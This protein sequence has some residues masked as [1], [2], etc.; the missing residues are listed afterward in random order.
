MIL[1]FGAG[2]GQLLSA[3]FGGYRSQAE[4]FTGWAEPAEKNSMI[5]Q[6]SSG[7]NLLS[8]AG[9]SVLFRPLV[10]VRKAFRRWVYGE[11]MRDLVR[12]RED[13]V[14]MQRQARH[15]LGAL[16]LRNDIRYAGKTAWTDAHRRWISSVVEEYVQAVQESPSRSAI[17]R[18]S[19]RA[20]YFPVLPV[21]GKGGSPPFEINR[22]PLLPPRDLCRMGCVPLPLQPPPLQP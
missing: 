16:L 11:A 2:R 3:S 18:R 12:A 1:T 14:A 6:M 15:R 21:R 9:M 13:A 22:D 5:V 4:C 7:A 10:V 20:R 17:H 8:K 19:N